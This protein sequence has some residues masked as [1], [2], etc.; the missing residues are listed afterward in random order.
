[1]DESLRKSGINLIG[2][3]PWGTHF[4]QFYSSKQDLLDI[5]IPYFKAGLQHNEFCMWVTSEPLGVD[6][7]KAALG[8]A[9]AGFDR[10]LK[11]GQIEIIPYSKWYVTGGTFDQGRVLNGWVRKLKNARR[12]GFA[13][14]R[15][16]GNTFW[17][18]KKDWKK[19][20]DYE[21]AVNS[22]I[23]KFK[24]LAICTYSLEKCGAAE[25]ADVISNHEFALI[26]K[27]GRWMR[28]ESSAHKQA[29][30]A[31]RTSEVRLKRAQEIAHLG[32]WELDLLTNQLTWSDEAYRIFGLKPQEFKATYEAFLEAVHPDD[33]K[34]VDE[35]YSG[36]L[37]DKKDRYEI[38]HRIV[39]RS[40]GEVRV[41]REKCEH[42]RDASGRIIRSIGMVHDITET[43]QAEIALQASE[44]KFRDL[45]SSMIE[46]VA[47][48]EVIYN[49]SA[50]AIDYRIVDVNPS[51]E[52]I[53]GL[54][55]LKA[56][57][58]TARQLYGIKEP[59]YLNIFAK[60][61][62]GA[63]PDFFET[64]FP[65]MDKHFSISVFSFA[66]GSFATVFQDIT[67]R[68]RAE[69]EI[70]HLAS[71]PHLNPNPVIE[72]DMRGKII[73]SNPATEKFLRSLKLPVQAK[74]FFPRDFSRILK[75]I[76]SGKKNEFLREV[77][78]KGRFFAVNI[79]GFRDLKVLRLYC[80][81]ITRR[82]VMEDEL[83]WNEQRNFILSETSAALLSAVDP[84]KVV[85]R[86]CRRAM[87]FLDCQVFFNFLSVP[88]INKLQ[89]NAYA[90]VPKREAQRIQWLEYGVAVCGCVAR[91][92]KRIIAENI[93]RTKDPRAKLVR[94]YGVRA[95]CC[96]P[97][98]GGKKVLGTISFG[99]TLRDTFT[100][101]E[102][103]MMKAIADI[104]AIAIQRKRMNEE[105]LLHEARLRF[106]IELT[107]HI[108]WVTNARG[109][110][111]EDIPSWRKFTGQSFKEIKGFGWIKAVHP[112]DTYRMLRAFKQASTA[113]NHYGIEYRVRS[114]EGVYRDFMARAVPLLNQ[115][116]KIEEW[117]GTC[118]DIT[119]RK[120]REEELK[121][122][123]R[124]LKALS[125]SSRAMMR[126]V[127]EQ[128]Y[129][130]EVCNIIT[131]D[132]GYPLIWI[133]Y[134]QEDEYKTVMSVAHAGLERGYLKQLNVSWA[135]TPRGQGPTGTAIRTGE[136]VLC[137]NM[138]TDP[139]FAPWRKQAF[140]RGFA[141]SAAFPLM[142]GGK[143]FGAL[144]LYS[145]IPEAFN[146]EDVKLLTQ[147]SNDLA[148]GITTLRLRF[149]HKKAEDALQQVNKDLEI[150]VARRTE[151]LTHANLNLIEQAKY[152]QATERTI[153]IRGALLKMTQRS[154]NRREFLDTLVKFLKG[155]SGCRYAG[156]R[157]LNE[158]G[159][160][161]YESYIGFSSEF[162]QNESR[163]SITS[164]QC[165]C[166]RVLT[167]NV[168]SQDM[169]SMTK[170]GSFFTNDS[171]GFVS[172]LTEK[173][174]ASFRG[175]CV[176]EGFSSIAVIP[177]KYKEQIIAGIHLADERKDM[178]AE[179]KIE[180][181][182]SLTNL[183]GEGIHK[184]EI[185]E[186]IMQSYVNNSVISALMRFAFKE[187]DIG[188]ILNRC[189]ELLLSLN[190]LSIESKGCIYLKEEGADALILR[191]QKNL[192]AQLLK[193]CARLDYGKCLCGKAAKEK[194]IVFSG[195]A[196]SEHEITY[197]GMPDHGHYCVPIMVGNDVLGVMNLYLPAQC[198]RDYRKEEFLASIANTM[199]GIIQRTLA[200]Q[201][202]QET[203][204]K[205]SNI[206]DSLTDGFF[207][208]D[209]DW[210]FTYV[211]PAAEKIL[212]VKAPLLV[213]KK[214]WDIF[215]DAVGTKIHS[216]QHWSMMEKV[217]VTF[218]AQ[219]PGRKSWLEFHAH[220]SPEGLSVYFKDV[221]ERKIGEEKLK[222]TQKQLEKSKR[223]SDI[224][225]LSATV[226]HELR[227]PLAAIQMAAY[228]I[229]RKAQNPL[230]ERHFSNIEKKVTESNQIITNLLFYSRLREP[231][232]E[233]VNLYSILDECIEIAKKR[234]Q[235]PGVKV[236]KKYRV[237]SRL[238]VEVDPLQIKEVFLNIV[239]NAYDAIHQGPGSI[240]I[241]ASHHNGREIKIYVTDSGAGM[242]QEDL[243]RVH[244]P[245]FTTK[246]KGTGLGLTVS[247]QIIDLH[248]GKIDIASR[249][250]LG[251][252]VAV[253]LPINRGNNIAEQ[254]ALLQQALLS[255]PAPAL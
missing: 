42:I 185:E 12:K 45:Y 48:L 197:E 132:C 126:A 174:K 231:H 122:F 43:K 84:Q 85:D 87:S 209:R 166:I 115:R 192:P 236:K 219:F 98:L 21:E 143:A 163:L 58:K 17:L 117:V 245:F 116:G 235:K 61:A 149:A 240:E 99:T 95:Y 16:T 123:N 211:N 23:G 160:I 156:L 62:S 20:T 24:M 9:V 234:A 203:G 204:E 175:V 86:V 33:R 212:G 13:G 118:V 52:K 168:L 182:E 195:S 177:I 30:A 193:E 223:L 46:G 120:Q 164:D 72:T 81:E 54:S 152:R 180:F 80:N 110:V 171:S 77:T 246:T 137:R 102:I 194:R 41:V 178:A 244:E 31:L 150:K 94:G 140:K 26:K 179:N 253:S 215:P 229:K 56:I 18:E 151:E 50:K 63:G 249:K 248:R 201:E 57:G 205:L 109:E 238:S 158:E 104:V 170:T 232:Y 190:W 127:N 196:G 227:N 14:L 155:L 144:T 76:R 128:A 55:R 161:P 145:K 32:S 73:F 106:N 37:R 206:L 186:R 230:L 184:F 39:R 199:A 35:A 3:F 15:L 139:K 4:C 88:E 44:R 165:A 34:A 2:D 82:K 19:F 124:T 142:S 113:K 147:L 97:L 226:A 125:E 53:T 36:S 213:G 173:E 11:K 157:V 83:R 129:L 66:K 141:S 28:I 91:E 7:A 135:D 60:V 133:G 188:K 153:R 5:L 79:V 159:E 251:T 247:F 49:K 228:N 224:G 89:L 40:S 6:E 29:D 75:D 169:P 181:L 22:V 207:A 191:A 130:K 214:E 148:Y 254:S 1:M 68:K 154:L 134:A 189:L 252:T 121:K 100:E 108:A 8:N 146:E 119:E 217:S 200:Q 103:S 101:R 198:R 38:E 233:R 239:N 220:P 237:L 255:N 176:Q 71:F 59:P 90:G 250:G 208:L 243:K 10:Y 162:I 27:S 107:G 111:V 69:K 70:Q 74:L 172:T 183:I 112:D 114:R 25:V 242:E 241:G 138:L 65:P 221:T 202:V 225:T 136:P 96:H 67:G 51:F 167:G 187:K 93:C 78:V 131:N 222:D 47:L 64:Y 218:E 210:K 216:E 105:L 92:G